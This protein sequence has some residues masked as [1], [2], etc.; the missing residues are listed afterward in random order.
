MRMLIA[1]QSALRPGFVLMAE[2]NPAP[3][4]PSARKLPT[5]L[6]RPVLFAAWSPSG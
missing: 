6:V 4:V 5:D 2:R 1:R 3:R